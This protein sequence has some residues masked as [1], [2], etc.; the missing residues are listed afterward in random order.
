M[1]E[2]RN[3]IVLLNTDA[4]TVKMKN[5]H[6]A[7]IAIDLKDITIGAYGLDYVMPPLFPSLDQHVTPCPDS[8]LSN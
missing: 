6:G 5:C 1:D 3:V 4:M 8:V 2:T 7:V